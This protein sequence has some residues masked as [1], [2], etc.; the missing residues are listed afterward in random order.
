MAEGS[1]RCDGRKQGFHDLALRLVGSRILAGLAATSAPLG[2]LAQRSSIGALELM[3]VTW[4]QLQQSRVEPRVARECPGAP[5][6]PLTVEGDVRQGGGWPLQIVA[7]RADK[8]VRGYQKIVGMRLSRRGPSPRGI[9][10]RR[11]QR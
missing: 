10:N 11:W 8:A 3:P 4:Q 7:L 6:E 2:S 1:G 5:G 9:P